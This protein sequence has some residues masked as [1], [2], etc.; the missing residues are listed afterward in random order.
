MID[1]GGEMILNEYI[2]NNL[3]SQQGKD[4]DSSSETEIQ[5]EEERRSLLLQHWRSVSRSATSQPSPPTPARRRTRVVPQTIDRQSSPAIGRRYIW[6]PADGQSPS[7]QHRR[8]HSAQSQHQHEC[9]HMNG[10]R[11]WSGSNSPPI[12]RLRTPADT[13]DSNP[14]PNFYRQNLDAN[15]NQSPSSQRDEESSTY[16]RSPREE[17][18]QQHEPSQPFIAQIIP[19]VATSPRCIPPPE[20]YRDCAQQ[21]R[22]QTALHLQ[23]YV[24]MKQAQMQM[25]AQLQR[26]PHTVFPHVEFG[27][28]QA[29]TV[30]P[31]VLDPVVGRPHSAP[32]GMHQGSQ[33]IQ[34]AVWPWPPP[35]VPPPPVAAPYWAPSQPRP[36]SAGSAGTL[37]R[38]HKDRPS[39]TEGPSSWNNSCQTMNLVRHKPVG[40]IAMDGR[41]LSVCHQNS[42]ES[43]TLSGADDASISSSNGAMSLPYPGI[44]APSP[45]PTLPNDSGTPT[46]TI[47]V[48]Q[49]AHV[50]NTAYEVRN[51]KKKDV[52]F[53]TKP[54]KN[55]KNLDS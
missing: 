47:S 52:P 44:N 48:I 55:S 25:H 12:R 27:L 51:K 15:D 41:E 8:A 54:F 43:G 10:E 34:V 2:S 17:Q 20:Q 46:S 7:P 28:R 33:A 24:A 3:F 26:A 40:Q 16:A 23:H 32:H 21:R 37:T 19:G 9:Q 31:F 50:F 49:T 6:G 39:P 53:G 30:R 45:I 13:W 11:D 22:Q 1:I 18:Q 36:R 14:K 38:Y 29:D 4:Y 42:N 35:R 5:I